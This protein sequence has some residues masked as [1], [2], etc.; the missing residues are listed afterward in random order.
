MPIT[1]FSWTC[2]CRGTQITTHSPFP[3]SHTVTLLAPCRTASFT[4]AVT[5]SEY[6][7][8]QKITRFKNTG[9]SVWMSCLFSQIVI[10]SEYYEQS[11]RSAFSAAVLS[12]S[13]SSTA[14]SPLPHSK[15]TPRGVTGC[16]TQSQPLPFCLSW[17]SSQSE[18]KEEKTVL[19]RMF[20]YRLS[21]SIT[22]ILQNKT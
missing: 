11:L 18:E 17:R 15:S 7:I 2:G 9:S 13:W 19:T 16:S 14:L 10:M 8:R 6:Q 22:K 21:I 3:I 12:Y 5:Q 4:T 1:S 20:S